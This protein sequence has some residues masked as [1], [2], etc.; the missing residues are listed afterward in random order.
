M[1]NAHK[2]GLALLKLSNRV[3]QSKASLEA[4]VAEARPCVPGG[5]AV[6]NALSVLNLEPENQES[7]SQANTHANQTPP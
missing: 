4:L 6:A 5:Q 3:L 2:R 1:S 7:T